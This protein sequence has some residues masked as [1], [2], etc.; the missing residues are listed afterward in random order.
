MIMQER[1]AELSLMDG[2]AV[3]IKFAI[4]KECL[5]HHLPWTQDSPERKGSQ[6]VT[7]FQRLRLYRCSPRA[8]QLLEDGI[9]EEMG[10]LLVSRRNGIWR[11][12]PAQEVLR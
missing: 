7:E 8:A 9:R 6:T 11:N 3:D 4:V 5:P 12:K 2:T 1:L 10:R